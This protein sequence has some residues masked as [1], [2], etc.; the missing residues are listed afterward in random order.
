MAPR[1]RFEL[2]TL[3]LT[4]EVIKTL[5]ALPGV[6][7]KKL[8]VILASLVAPNSAPNDPSGIYLQGRTKHKEEPCV[9]KAADLR[10]A[11]FPGSG[12]RDVDRQNEATT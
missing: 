7:Y 10:G 9:L 3:L 5:S 1:A 11:R 2:A 6:A 12:D 4:A 8:G